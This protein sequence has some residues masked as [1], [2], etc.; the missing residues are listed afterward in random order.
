VRSGRVQ[1]PQADAAFVAAGR[2][3]LLAVNTP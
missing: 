3:V 1:A 2:N